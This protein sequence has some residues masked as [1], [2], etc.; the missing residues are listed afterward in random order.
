MTLHNRKSSGLIV[1]LIVLISAFGCQSKKKAMQASNAAAE[2]ARIEQE[3]N[4]KKLK[5][6]EL[7]MQQEKAMREEEERERARQNESKASTPAV[8]LNQYF[9]SIASSSNATSA[10]AS[11]NEA[12]G[13][14]ASPQTPV[15]IVISESNG[16][17]D[18]DKPT[19]I[20]DYLNYLKDQKKNINSISDVKTDASGK[21]TE[22]E[23]RK[24]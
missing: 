21:I 20:K 19:T 18:Y 23:L 8:K 15:L 9:S 7:A 1:L 24:N 14:F 12:L 17:K 5:E 4:D 2:K 11:I 6:Q 16:E 10:N 13:L 3:Q 22:L